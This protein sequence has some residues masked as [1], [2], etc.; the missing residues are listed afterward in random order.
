M[1]LI[2]YAAFNSLVL[3]QYN[4]VTNESDDCSVEAL[5]W[6]YF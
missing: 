3:L 6:F 5:F 1:V 2:F 4:L